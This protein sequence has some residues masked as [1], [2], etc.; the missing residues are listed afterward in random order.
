MG[1]LSC[2]AQ[3]AIATCDPH[4]K[5]HKPIAA[6]PI[7]HFNYAEIAAAAS[8]FSAETFLGR[9]SHGRVYKATL[10]GGKLLAAVKTTKLVSASKNHSTKCTGCGNCTSPVENEIEI[11]SQVPSPRVVNLIGFST[12]PNGNKLIVVEYMPNGS[13]HDLLHSVRKPPGWN[14]RVRFAVQVAKA[15]RELH[16]ANPPV[17]HRDVKSSN[18]L[19]DERWNARLGDFGLALRGHVEDV[20]VK[21]TPP[22]GTIGYL[23]PC[24]LAPEDLSAKS[25]VFSFGILLL[26]IIS[27]R[28]A[29]DVNYS[30]SS[31]VDW[32]VPLIKLGDFAGICDRRIGPP[33]DPA[34]VRQLSVL[35]ARC[36]RSTA[37]KRP[38]MMEVVEC[39]NLARKRI[40]ASPVWM[41]LRRR[42]AR[43]ESA[44]PVVAWEECDDNS[45]NDCDRSEKFASMV[46][47]GSGSRRKGKVSSVWGVGYGS[48]ASNNHKV[49][50][51][52][53][54]G[55]SSGSIRGSWVKMQPHQ[56]EHG[57][58]RRKV[59]LKKSKS[60][61]VLQGSVLS[62][63]TENSNNRSYSH[64]YNNNNNNGDD[65]SVIV[66]AMAKL[67]VTDKLEKK[68]VEKP[69]VKLHDEVESVRIENEAMI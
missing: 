63:Y 28:N 12:D 8:G 46:K 55:S 38:S 60:L 40:R 48:E 42:V 3:S 34:V 15:V 64:S 17:I 50:R 57:F 47:G 23:D 69:L 49:I 26:E 10:D 24:Y 6:K 53:S 59:R 45:I 41:S 14:R 33:P 43:M 29:I 68:M 7:R 9:G 16:S 36:V 19:I 5:K 52:K 54:I 39:L 25:D 2:N 35:A 11:L 31:I 32:A 1:Y 65:V 4:F 67:V 13:L 58:G 44:V 61:G 21:C 18:V 51:S 27:G 20:R 37:E 30:P 62:H 22:A 56:T 66:S